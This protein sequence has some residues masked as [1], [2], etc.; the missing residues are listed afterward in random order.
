MSDNMKNIFFR[1]VCLY[2]DILL[3][4]SLNT[5]Q[6]ISLQ[7][8]AVCLFFPLDGTYIQFRYNFEVSRSQGEGNLAMVA[9]I[10]GGKASNLLSLSSIS[11]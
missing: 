8:D 1:T 2:I 3:R 9:V 10:D 4:H 6:S 11:K 7:V 5:G